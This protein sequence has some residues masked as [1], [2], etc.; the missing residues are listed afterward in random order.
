MNKK[1]DAFERCYNLYYDD[2]LKDKIYKKTA[3]TSGD[4][5]HC[6]FD[7]KEITDNEAYLSFKECNMQ[8][9]HSK[10]GNV[11]ICQDCFEEIKKRHTLKEEKNTVEDIERALSHFKTVV[12]SLENEQYIIKNADGKIAVA[13]NS[14]ASEYDDILQMEREQA[15]YGKPLREMIDDIFIGII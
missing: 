12:I 7:A 14:K 2:F 4:H 9:Y 1:Q 15:F 13:H 3:F 6:L 10:T 8:G 5:T 11:W